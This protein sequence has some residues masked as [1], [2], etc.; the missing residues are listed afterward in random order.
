MQ[1]EI[2]LDQAKSRHRRDLIDQEAKHRREMEEKDAVLRSSSDRI[3]V[4]E[5]EL[6]RIKEE[7]RLF[8]A[9]V[10]SNIEQTKQLH[11]LINQQRG[12]LERLKGTDVKLEQLKEAN[13]DMKETVAEMKRSVQQLEKEKS[14]AVLNLLRKRVKLQ[15]LK[16]TVRGVRD[17]QKQPEVV[18]RES[19]AQHV[20]M[21]QFRL[22]DE[23]IAQRIQ[24]LT[25]VKDR[26]QP[27]WQHRI[28]RQI[29][30][31]AAMETEE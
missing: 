7:N 13:L 17:L 4:L 9:S 2:N 24:A 26:F 25:P 14:D 16:E 3:N 12:E 15:Q 18:Q 22:R 31:A 30:K 6:E 5:A 8:K 1:L 23:E 27:T 11:A 29:E 19:P 10:E 20:R 28:E 21:A